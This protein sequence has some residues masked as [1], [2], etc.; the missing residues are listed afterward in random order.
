MADR[1]SSRV[2][3]GSKAGP[4]EALAAAEVSLLPG[5]RQYG[6]AYRLYAE[7]LAA[8]PDVP[9]VPTRYEAASAAVQLLAGRDPAKMV[10][11]EESAR[12][13]R[14]ARE[15]LREAVAA[16]PDPQAVRRRLKD[17]AFAPVREPAGLAALPV[18]E[19]TEWERLWADV[20]HRSERPMAGENG[21]G[22]GA[23][24]GEG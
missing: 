19:R 18:A 4:A 21:S 15:W 23:A 17:P 7:T 9:A 1:G 5:F 22:P 14:Q 13:H 11:P 16:D 24:D 10:D 3:F 12:L 8:E 20:A 2:P 6:L